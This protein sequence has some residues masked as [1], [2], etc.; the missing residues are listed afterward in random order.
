MIIKLIRFDGPSLNSIWQT[1]SRDT[2]LLGCSLE[3][4]S[5]LSLYVSACYH[6]HFPS[7]WLLL[8]MLSCLNTV[9]EENWTYC[10]HGSLSFWMV[11]L[12][13]HRFHSLTLAS[14][15]EITRPRTPFRLWHLYGRMA[16]LLDGWLD[17]SSLTISVKL[18]MLPGHGSLLLSNFHF[19]GSR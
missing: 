3:L 6:N 19:W 7:G 16:H 13:P 5:C 15:S 8:L 4:I 12:W 1:W 9:W 10:R 14:C 2:C 18:C 17:A 11:A